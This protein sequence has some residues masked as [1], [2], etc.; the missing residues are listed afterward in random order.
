LPSWVPGFCEPTI[1]PWQVALGLSLFRPWLTEG[2]IIFPLLR[3]PALSVVT[4]PPPP[5][6]E[7]ATQI[8]HFDRQGVH[9]ILRTAH[10]DQ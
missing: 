3:L 2:K 5:Y 6:A 8:M 1:G 9:R 7:L 10:S 4:L